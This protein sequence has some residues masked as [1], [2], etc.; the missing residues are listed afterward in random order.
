[1]NKKIEK[2]FQNWQ[3]RNIKG[4]YCATKAAALEKI[5]ELV[6]K[7][8]SVGLSGSQTVDALAAVAALEARGTK[9]YNQYRPGISRGESVELRRQGATQADFYLTGINAISEQGELVFFSAYG[10][11]IAGIS[12]GKSVIVVAGVN[13]LVPNLQEALKRS[14]EVATPLN[15]KRLNYATP[16]FQDGICRQDICLFPEYTRMCC[17][18]LVIEAEIAP[19]RLAVVLVNEN[20][21]F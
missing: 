14:R 11:R 17:Q 6:P 15:C 1:M 19:D 12:Y 18:V 7:N 21:G 9:V 4:F 20:L 13:K 16:C 5:L 10:N 8:A 3:K 2:L